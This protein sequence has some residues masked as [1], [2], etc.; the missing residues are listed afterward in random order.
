[1]NLV[2]R[3]FIV[4]ALVLVGAAFAIEAGSRFWIRAAEATGTAGLPRPGLGI[5]SLAAL[6]PRSLADIL[7]VGPTGSG[8]QFTQIQAAVNAAADDDV[9]LV[10]AG[11]YNAFV[12]AKP[13]RILKDGTGNAFIANC[14]VRDIGPGE[15]VVLS[16]L[17]ATPPS[18]TAKASWPSRSRAPRKADASS[19]RG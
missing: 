10:K 5:P 9:I 17:W 19:M 2:R 6:A 7:T 16:G 14:E 11:N 15:E 4:A 18:I 3:P 8:S 12:V 13:V 1:M